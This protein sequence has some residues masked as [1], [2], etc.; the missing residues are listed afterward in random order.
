MIRVSFRAVAIKITALSFVLAATSALGQAQTARYPHMAPLQQYLMDRRAE[1]ALAQSAAPRPI[2]QHATVLVLTPAG[3]QVVQKGSDGFTCL[4]ERSWMKPFDDAEF[5]NWKMRGPVCYNAE[6]SST[7]L[8]YTYKRT[9]M[10][11]AGMTESAIFDR[12][13]ADVAD[14][15][16]LA[17]EPGSMAYMMSKDQYL[18]DDGK[19]WMP[20]V[21]V[22]T[23][24]AN[25]ANDG[26]SWGADQTGSPVLFD[27]DHHVNP[28]PWAL[29]FIPVSHWSDGSPAPLMH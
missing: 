17:P 9:D 27:S 22:Y 18:A 14:K 2:A 16:L 10:V 15:Q 11:L 13:K 23:P 24:K 8:P 1:I 5:W 20:H 7:V 12:I 19:A 28:E 3:Y 21:M 6:A 26:A 29:F 4:V 25:A